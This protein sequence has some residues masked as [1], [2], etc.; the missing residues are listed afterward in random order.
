MTDFDALLA[1]QALDTGVDQLRHRRDHL[2][3]R[4]ELATRREELAAIDR[5]TAEVQARRD[6]LAQSERHLE[7]QIGAVRAKAEADDKA[8]YGGT[9]SALKDLR[10]LQDEIASLGRRQRDLEDQELALMEEAEPLDAELARSAEAR[11]QLDAEVARLLDAIAAAEAAIDE[12]LAELG[13]QRAGLVAPVPA[14]LLDEY[15]RKRKQAGGIAVARLV[16]NRCEGCHLTLSAVDIDRIR[17][18]PP[19]ALVHCTECDRI[20]VR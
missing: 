18:E 9:V 11:H 5:S 10:A 3:E 4:A 6:E 15:D 20:L 16:G 7:E 2:P 14:D 19:D 17:H 12:E 1:L 13:A 8:L